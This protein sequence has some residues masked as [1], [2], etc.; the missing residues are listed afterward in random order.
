MDAITATEC[1]VYRPRNPRRSPLYQ[2]VI[3]H[4]DEL[5]AAERIRRKVEEQALERFLDCGDLH[6]GFAR[7][8]CDEC[9]HDYLLAFSCKTRCF[10]PSCHQKRML[11]FGEW[12]DDE[13]L[14]PV[15]HRQYVFTVPKLL[16]PHF[17]RRHRLGELCRLAGGLLTN[18][19]REALPE[20]Q[21]AFILFVQT[22]GDLVNFNPHIHALVADGVFL[23]NGVFQ[24]LPPIPPALLA[25]QFRQAVLKF[26]A[27]EEAITPDMAARLSQWRYSGFSVHNEVRIGASDENG[28]QQLARYMIRAPFSLEKTEYKPD[29]GVVVYR[30]KMHASLKRNFQIMPGAK[31]LEMLLQH[32]PD[33]GEH[34]VRYYGWY[35]NRSRGQR[36]KALLQSPHLDGTP[37]EIDPELSRA[38][39][40]AWARL[41]QK[42]YEVDP[43]LC[44]R[45]GAP[46]RIVAVIEEK[47]VIERILRHIGA[48]AP[49]PPS[50][51][52]PEHDDWPQNGQI[53]LTYHPLPDIA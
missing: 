13:V 20:G 51:A 11:V 18:N 22:F 32:V 41:I 6:K 26:L 46:M 34:L 14:A 49:R 52:P 33:K 12:V 36:R 9:R 8:Y 29:K 35:S 47:L 19:L 5:R 37:E 23:D 31:W 48:W 3:R 53:P 7:I 43:M 30:S 4:G 44:P 16:R 17:H 21:P 27:D 42:V 15:P 1:P 38:A 45:C 50:Q 2:C 25:E 39:K 24:V 28:R 40:A 10:C